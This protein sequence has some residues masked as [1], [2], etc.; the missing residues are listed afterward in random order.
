[1]ICKKVMNLYNL[2]TNTKIHFARYLSINIK[3]TVST[4][5]LLSKSKIKLQVNQRYQ[6]EIKAWQRYVD[7]RLKITIIISTFI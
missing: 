6:G 4:K 5:Q 7:A 1:M 2:K 3:K